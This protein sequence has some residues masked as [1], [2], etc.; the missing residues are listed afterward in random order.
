MPPAPRSERNAIS[1]PSGESE[2][3]RSSAGSSVRRTAPP[4]AVCCTQMSR[5]P[6]PP[7]SEAYATS[8]PSAL[9]LGSV[10]SPL[11]DVNRVSW[12]RRVAQ[13]LWSRLTPAIDAERRDG[14]E[15]QHR[16]GLPD[17]H[18]S[19]A[20]CG[21]DHHGFG[22]FVKQELRITDVTEASLRI[23]LERRCEQRAHAGRSVC[24]AGVTSRERV[25]RRPRVC[26]SSSRPQ[27][28]RRRSASRTARTR[29]PRCRR[30]CRRASR[31][32]AQGSCRPR[33]RESHRRARAP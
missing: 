4:P 11:S 19:R 24:P 2:G 7:R 17:A 6:P 12:R 14:H 8:R 16:D 5:L 31:A 26:R 20:C 30:A 29:T 33:C 32:P 18:A 9:I 21:R 10:V 23:L 1:V 15:G 27:T 22:P 13:G 3:D 25:P 28:A